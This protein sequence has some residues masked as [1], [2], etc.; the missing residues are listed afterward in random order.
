MSWKEP[1]ADDLR[2]L[3]ASVPYLA[4]DL[5]ATAKATGLIAPDT[6]RKTPRSTPTARSAI[7]ADPP[8]A[9][10]LMRWVVVRYSAVLR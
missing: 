5:L 10:F 7:E 9:P 3:A 6:I 8:W 2:L 4:I 1:L